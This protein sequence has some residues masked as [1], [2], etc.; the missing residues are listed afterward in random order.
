M[1]MQ[2]RALLVLAGLMLP[3]AGLAQDFPTLKPGLWELTRQSSRPQDAAQRIT[4]CVDA[5]VQRQ[6]Y[7]VGTGAMRGMCSKHEFHIRGSRGVGE[8]VCNLGQSTVHSKSVMT[9]SGDTAY[10]TETELTYDPPF[11][12]QSRSHSVLDARYTGACRT[13]QRPGD[14]TLPNGRTIN[15]RDALGA[16]PGSAAA[17]TGRPR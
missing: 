17:P 2:P 4:I 7:D 14:M 13:G 1:R 15:L 6:M 11:M 10:R 3:V 8:F 16:L 12:G 9:I 5:T